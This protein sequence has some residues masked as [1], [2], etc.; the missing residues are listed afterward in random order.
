VGTDELITTG[1]VP[2]TEKFKVERV[3]YNAHYKEGRPPSIKVS[4]FC[5]LRMFKEFICLEHQG[6]ARRKARE[7]WRE[8]SLGEKPPETTAEALTMFDFLRTP[9]HINVWL[10]KGSYDEIIGYDYE[11]VE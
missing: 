9:S 11:R 1:D 10:K 4:Y 8:R 6:Y 7:W 5:G 2:V 3:V